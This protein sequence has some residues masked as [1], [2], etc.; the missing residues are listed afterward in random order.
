MVFGIQDTV[1]LGLI[2]V[3]V[4]LTLILVVVYSKNYR[5]I[6]SKMTLGLLFFA[7]AF[8]FENLIDLYFYNLMITQLEFDFTTIHFAVNFIEMIG[9]FV[10]SYITWK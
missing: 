10:L 1:T 2:I 5:A 6:K 8:L 7:L 4:I 3:N 9:L